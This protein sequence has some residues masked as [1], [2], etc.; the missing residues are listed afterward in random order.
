MRLRTGI[1][2][3]LSLAAVAPIAT[4]SATARYLQ[5]AMEPRPGAQPRGSY[6]GP[7]ICRL[8]N[9]GFRSDVSVAG[10]PMPARRMIVVDSVLV[11]AELMPLLAPAQVTNGARSLSSILRSA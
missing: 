7:C 10:L 6:S 8:P 11:G 5:E 1:F 3:G 4:R 9:S 2:L